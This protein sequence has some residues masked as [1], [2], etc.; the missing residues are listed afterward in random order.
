MILRC[1]I[2][3]IWAPREGG[4]GVTFARVGVPIEVVSRLLAV[5]EEAGC[6]RK[7]SCGPSE[8]ED[9]SGRDLTQVLPVVSM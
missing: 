5:L 3:W 4:S 2:I 7:P 8:C 1:S 6:D 9:R